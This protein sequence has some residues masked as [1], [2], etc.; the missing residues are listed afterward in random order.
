MVAIDPELG[1]IQFAADLTPPQSLRVTYY[2]GFPAP[3][4]GGPYDRT[5][6]LGEEV[7]TANPALANFFALV[8]SAEFP[9]L[10]SAV[11]QWNLQPA[12]ST[13][14]IVLPGFERYAI[15]L[16]GAN[17]I[18]L[19]SGSTLAIAAGVALP[20]SGGHDMLWDKAYVTLLGTIE[21][22]GSPPPP[23][24]E[25]E[26]A[27]VGQLI[28]NGLLIEGQL[29][30]DG[31]TVAV[32]VSDCTLVPGLGAANPGLSPCEPSIVID[33]DA[34]LCMARCI[35]GPIAASAAA[36]VRIC[37]SIV[38]ANSPCCVAY[39][40]NDGYSAGADLH[41]EDSTVIGKVRT[42]TMQLASNTIFFARL[43][44]HDPWPAA[45]WC[46]RVQ[47]GCI[48]F[49]SLPR[50]SIT[51]RCYE[52]LPPDA[53]SASIFEPT[54]IT[55]RYGHP[56]YALLSGD[57]PMAVWH[58]ADNGSQMGVY[59]QI[60][61]TEAVANVQIRTPEYLPV[62]L[63]SGI[64]LHPSQPLL[65]LIPAPF[66]YDSY[67]GPVVNCCGDDEDELVGLPGIGANLL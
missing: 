24:P 30:L 41:I 18:A 34:T 6:S 63:E 55:L 53:A 28:I 35:T 46:S 8:G 57:V 33:N 47:V 19:A 14:V 25:G 26:V 51:P 48:R 1:R 52:C 27:P 49:C 10:A 43:G 12:G 7:P 67:S 36:S 66:A 21:V 3:I 4:G 23:M 13:G 5:A 65:R 42:R 32:Q 64:F 11:T 45:L 29:T 54:F 31:A 20:T 60:Q 22:T 50:V 56:S 59:Y 58:G 37:N 62:M 2:Y 61:E 44:R 17:A 16:T 39:S 9:D 40:G 38:D 15:D